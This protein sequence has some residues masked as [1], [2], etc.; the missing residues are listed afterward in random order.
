VVGLETAADAAGAAEV[1]TGEAAGAADAGEGVDWLLQPVMTK[2]QTNRIVR[3][4][5]TFLMCP[6]LINY[7]YSDH[8]HPQTSNLDESSILYFTSAC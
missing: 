7:S 4:M 8:G 1:F 2:A 3:G 6:P 5:N